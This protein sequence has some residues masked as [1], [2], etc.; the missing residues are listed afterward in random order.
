MPR[1]T[2]CPYYID[3]NK[4]SIS[5]EDVCRSFRSQKAKWRWMDIYCDSWE[6]MKCPW[7]ADISEA[8]QRFEKGDTMALDEQKLKAQTKEIKY[9]RTRLGKAEK[10]NEALYARWKQTD[11]ELREF[12]NNAAEEL[13]AMAQIYEQRMCYLI[14][15]FAPEGIREADI[16]EWAADKE[17]ALVADFTDD[18]KAISWKVVFKEDEPDTDLQKQEQK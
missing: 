14:D 9:L 2:L 15:R 13:S 6:W 16:K 3:E 8:Y 17:F 1:Y 4:K 12:R 18:G 7:A 11:Q 10:R 5:C